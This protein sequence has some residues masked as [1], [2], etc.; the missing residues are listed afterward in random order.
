MVFCYNW[1]F[2]YFVF[3]LDCV[4]VCCGIGSFGFVCFGDFFIGWMYDVVDDV[5]M[6]GVYD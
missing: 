5:D 2:E 3:E 6:F 1:C 4:F